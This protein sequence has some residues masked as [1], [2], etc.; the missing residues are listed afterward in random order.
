[1]RW[2]HRRKKDDFDEEI[3]THLSLL[4][5]RFIAQGMPA[6]EAWYAARRQFGNSTALKEVRKDMDP[7]VWLETLWQDLRYALR[8][9]GNHKAFST[10]AILTLA[11]GIGANTAIFSV[12]NAVIIRPLPYPEPD[13]LMVLWGNVKRTKVERRGTSYPDYRDWRDQNHSF[14]AMAAAT[15]ERFALTGIETPERIAGEYVSPAYFNLLGVRAA[16]GRTFRP[17]EDEVPQRDA[18]VVLSDGTWKRRFGAD[19]SIVGRSIQLN[20]R[21]FTVVGVAPP[22]FRGVTDE[23][24]VWVPFLMAGTAADFGERGTR[25][26]QALARLKPGVSQAA[27]QADMDAISK[28]LERAHPATNEARGVEV[29]SLPNET[30]GPVRAP[31]L[32]LL[33]A[34]G[35]VLLIASTNV[36]NLLLARS[37]ARQHEVAMRKALGASGGRLLRQLLAESCVLVACGCVAGL[38]VAHYGTKVLI[39]ASPLTFPSFIQPTIDLRVAAFTILVCC[40][41]AL[42][43]AIAPAIQVRAGRFDDALRQNATRTT[44]SRRAP[45]FRDALVIAEISLSM[46]LLVGAGLM[47]RSLQHL[48]ALNPGYDPTHVVRLRVSLPRIAAPAGQAGA[49][50]QNA[51][52]DPNAKVAVAAADILSRISRSPGVESASVSTDT[53]MGGSSA[54]FYAAEGQPP[55][56]AQNAPR[57][58]FHRVSP[59]FFQ[60]LH[61]QFVSGRSFTD[62]EVRGNA[63]VAV[64]TQNMV[65]RFWPGQDPIGKRVKIGGL[66]SQRPW[67]NII[68]VVKELKYRGLPD[69]PTPDPDLFQVFNERSRDFSVLVRTSL[70]PGS[71]LKSIRST[72]V[73]AEPSILIYN[74]GTLEELMA[75]QISRPRF[76]G[77]LMGIFAAV[78]LILAA[79][80]IYGVMAYTVSRRT[81][82]IGLRMALGAGRAEVL[83]MVVT[84]GMALVAAGLIVGAAAALGLTRL[85]ATLIY[86]VSPTDPFAFTAAAATLAAVALIACFMPASRASRIDPAVALRNE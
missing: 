35:F 47:I 53:P 4:A 12:V 60:T 80:G 82:E 3:C 63:N 39:A 49:P 42:A 17:E 72:V 65:A 31:L 21:A 15:D 46:L 83:R 13:R 5:E 20:G 57:A 54:V 28:R 11:H 25:G 77:W 7:F 51:P 14:E 59:A 86:G 79:I 37:E 81:R 78:A 30:F 71:M 9:L 2:F 22:G 36:A 48:T 52:P 40:G 64:V 24:E 43:L 23:A 70:E 45:R 69:N 66:N 76:T 67:L 44:D 73:E 56:T 6:D 26:F 29:I 38:V 55:M 8:V 41:I 58:Y 85:V 74:A 19:P 50:A 68:G 16:M 84:R 34:V 61:A 75:E 32:V 18:V 1:M 33:G 27:A 10:V 62:D